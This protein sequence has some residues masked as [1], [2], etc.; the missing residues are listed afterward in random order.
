MRRLAP[1]DLLPQAT[2]VFERHWG[3]VQRIE[4]L[5]SGRINDS[6]LVTVDRPPAGVATN[7][8]VLQRINTELF[9]LHEQLIEQSL[10]VVNHLNTPDAEAPAD[11][12]LITPGPRVPRWLASRDGEHAVWS[13]DALWRVLWFIEGEPLTQGVASLCDARLGSAAA[14]FADL[15]HALESLPGERLK[16][17]IPYLYHFDL[18]LDAFDAVAAQ[19]PYEWRQRVDRYRN[20]VVTPDSNGWLH[21]R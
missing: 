9:R 14:A 5:G 7:R 18:T 11:D 8:F 2:A 15:Q 3:G 17:N 21:P 20:P 19:A 1:E 13:A 6:F 12:G 10:R 4:L 16:P